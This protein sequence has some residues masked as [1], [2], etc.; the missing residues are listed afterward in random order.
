MNYFVAVEEGFHV[1]YGFS[2]IW[3][4]RS[5]GL[6]LSWWTY[7]EPFDFG[8][9]GVLGLCPH[10]HRASPLKSG[11]FWEQ[12]RDGDHTAK[13]FL[14]KFVWDS[15]VD[16]AFSL[17][18][19]L[20]YFFWHVNNVYGTPTRNPILGTLRR[21]ALLHCP[22]LHSDLYTYLLLHWNML[23]VYILGWHRYLSMRAQRYYQIECH[24]EQEWCSP[25][26]TFCKLF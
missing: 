11:L 7:E 20:F 22:G 17:F 18:H 19:F 12:P 8:T 25:P 10:S 5:P 15:T 6:M 23:I 2:P 1:P 14:K 16:E 21:L 4:H 26:A 9:H 24:L 13:C 3:V